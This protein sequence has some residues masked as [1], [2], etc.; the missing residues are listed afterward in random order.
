ML[1]AFV[2]HLGGSFNEAA[3]SNRGKPHTATFFAPDA[4]GLQ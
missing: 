3:A 4:T 2:A 1:K